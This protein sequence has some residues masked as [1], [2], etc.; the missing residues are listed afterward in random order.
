MEAYIDGCGK[1]QSFKVPVEEA[2]KFVEDVYAVKPDLVAMKHRGYPQK[3]NILNDI[4]DTVFIDPRA[5][6]SIQPNAF[7]ISAT[8]KSGLKL[9][10]LCPDIDSEIEKKS[11]MYFNKLVKRLRGNKTHQ[12]LSTALGGDLFKVLSP[13]L[14]KKRKIYNKRLREE[15]TVAVVIGAS[16]ALERVQNTRNI[17]YLDIDRATSFV[18]FPSGTGK[19]SVVRVLF[20]QGTSEKKPP[21]PETT[22]LYFETDE[23]A[24]AEVARLTKLKQQRKPA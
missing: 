9:L 1:L 24:K 20:E 7:D 12:E 5:I 13:R 15:F 11:S 23:K 8:F 16:Q 6:R 3:Q 4:K 19:E 21:F 14:E 22:P 2:K 10:G 17:Y 18:F